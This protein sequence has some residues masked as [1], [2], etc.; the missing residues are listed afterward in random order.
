MNSITLA[1]DR[2]KWQTVVNKIFSPHFPKRGQFSISRELL[3]SQQELC[4]FKSVTYFAS[5]FVNY[6]I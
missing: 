6:I 1:E 5:Y 2:E 4:S 3:A